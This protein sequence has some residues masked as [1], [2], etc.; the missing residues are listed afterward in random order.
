MS[1]SRIGILSIGEMGYHWAR[2]L[3]D[4]GVEVLTYSKGRSEVSQKRAQ[5]AG[6]R[7]VESLQDLVSECDLIVS[8]VVPSA[9]KKVARQVAR[10]LDRVGKWQGLFLDANA[11]SP[12]SA[13]EIQ[14]LF[15]GNSCFVDGCI[16]GS[17]T[18]MGKSSVVYVSGPEANRVRELKQAGISV[19]VL[20]QKI[21]QASAFKIIYAGLT[22]GLQ[23]LFVELLLG[24]RRF[25]L[26]EEILQRYEESF[27]GLPQKVAGTIAA[28]PL[29]AGRRAQE[30]D[31]LVRTYR[32]NG[33]NPVLAPATAR[34]LRK[35]GSLQAGK[36]S[37]TA[38]REGDLR[39]TL[40]L[41]F[42]LGLLQDSQSSQK[43]S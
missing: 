27:P 28:L 17:A 39:G 5:N 24:A 3:H 42:R 40:E 32:L 14:N 11:I 26:L 8:I 20:G 16:I 31:E 34:L 9:A 22:K 37:E 29:H 21:G 2:L 25:D 41:L 36:P 19:A 38:T 1:F 23:S 30:M 15:G 7:S 10:T 43:A 12:V 18:K 6:V 33:M 35:I 4:H 13:G